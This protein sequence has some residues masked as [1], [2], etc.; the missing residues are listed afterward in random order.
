MLEHLPRSIDALHHLEVLDIS[1]NS[2]ASL[3]LPISRLP[4][5]RIFNIGENRLT[6]LPSFLGLLAKTLTVLLVDGNP[7]NRAHQA[8]IE[9]ILI[10]PPKESRQATIM[11]ERTVRVPKKATT[12]G[13]SASSDTAIA[14]AADALSP[15]PKSKEYMAAIRQLVGIGFRRRHRRF[16]DEGES[17]PQVTHGFA[18]NSKHP[19]SIDGA[20]QRSTYNRPQSLSVDA[21]A[22][23]V[24]DA[25]KVAHVLWRLRDEWD[26]D[27]KL[28]ESLIVEKHIAQQCSHDAR[29]VDVYVTDETHRVVESKPGSSLRMKIL[30]ELLVTEVT[31]VDTLKNVVGVYLN[32]MREAKILAESE[33]RKIFSNV[34]V[35]LAFHNDHFLPAIT[36]ALSQ[37]LMAIGNVF[38]QH[39]AHFRL[40]STY[41]NSHDTS[42]RTL[43]AVASRRPVSSF[44]H[45][46]RHDVT[47]IGQV[48]LDG[49]LLTPVQR[50]P[51]YRLLLTGILTNTP[52]THPDYQPLTAALCE[53]NRSIHEVNERKRVHE[54]LLLLQRLQ[55]Q[56][57]GAADIPLTVPHRVLKLVGSFRLQ[58]LCTSPTAKHGVAL[59]R[60]SVGSVHRYFLFNDMLLQC[61]PGMNK[62]MRVSRVYWL[63]SRLKPA[64]ITHDHSLRIVDSDC[65][66]YLQGDLENV[67]RWA[68]EINRRLTD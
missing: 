11:V 33:L 25:A 53:L 9:P 46:A 54:N 67:R 55:E 41:T 1:R 63:R 29:I 20:S 21:P 62:D 32:P 19:I 28:S 37:P 51:R 43:A 2:I 31:Y 16:R 34:E 14:D 18:A 68:C 4:A 13:E 59:K 50:L 5:L 7:F 44:L 17:A 40:Y 58:S 23:L 66:L 45:N 61:L 48:T 42:V 35:I 56:I 10:T 64:D 57:T 60:I 24:Q 3:D 52:H 6:R 8:L 27:P 12:Q 49:H 39:S 26:L 36:H 47:Q 15:L 38:L 22:E 65:I 30:S